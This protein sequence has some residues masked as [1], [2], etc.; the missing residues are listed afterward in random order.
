MKRKITAA[1]WILSLALLLSTASASGGDWEEAMELIYG[2]EY[3]EALEAFKNM[4]DPD[5]ARPYVEA[6]SILEHAEMTQLSERT[7]GFLF[8]GL[9]GFVSFPEGGDVLCVSPRWT[10]LSPLKEGLLLTGQEWDGDVLYG[11]VTEDARVL[12]PGTYHRISLSGTDRLILETGSE[13]PAFL[14]SSEEYAILSSPCLS[15][16]EAG[17]GLWAFQDTESGKWG[18]MDR[19]GRVCAEPLWDGLGASGDALIPALKDGLWGY[20]DA[21]GETVIPF[22]YPEAGP[23]EEGCADVRELRSGW[24]IISRDGSVL[25]FRDDLKEFDPE[26]SGDEDPQTAGDAPDTAADLSGEYTV[27]AVGHEDYV[28]VTVTL[29]RE[30]TILKIAVDASCEDRDRG[31]H[32]EEVPFTEQFLGKKGPFELGG[33]IDGITGATMT[34]EAVV[35]ALNSLYR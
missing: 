4:P 22:R 9:W 20:I 33:E 34:S 19:E 11:V 6:L 12:Y 5:A 15:L 28:F 35:E 16:T 17:E 29:D 31:R 10:E 2:G 21:Q 26:G 24:R 30:G 18:L 27:Y 25:Y 3:A 23:F 8:H 13:G 7:A 32:A 1:L 14:A